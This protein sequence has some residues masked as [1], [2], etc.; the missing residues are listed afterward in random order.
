M[1]KPDKPDQQQ[2]LKETCLALRKVLEGITDGLEDHEKRLQLLER[3]DLKAT[4]EELKNRAEE[5]S[6]PKKKAEILAS[7]KGLSDL[8]G[9]PEFLIDW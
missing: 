1:S 7:V 8:I 3:A 5:I 2:L 4:L 6:D 9:S